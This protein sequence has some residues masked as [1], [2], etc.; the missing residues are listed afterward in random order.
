MRDEEA[1][2][3]ENNA[4]RQERTGSFARINEYGSQLWKVTVFP[5]ETE[6]GRTAP[7]ELQ[8]L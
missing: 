5:G 2:I 8:Q 7:K 1:L 3:Q 6:E 4:G